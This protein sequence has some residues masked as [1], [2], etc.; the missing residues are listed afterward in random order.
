MIAFYRKR[1][2]GSAKLGHL[3]EVP[4]PGF[5]AQPVCR[6]SLLTPGHMLHTAPCPAGRRHTGLV[7]HHETDGHCFPGL[8]GILWFRLAQSL[9]GQLPRSSSNFPSPTSHPTAAFPAALKL[10]LFLTAG[11]D[12]R[13]ISRLSTLWETRGSLR[14]SLRY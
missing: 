8:E 2:Q 4:E 14:Y 11:E 6:P 1:K 9:G 7:F 3:S 5:A 13:E 10:G 12:L